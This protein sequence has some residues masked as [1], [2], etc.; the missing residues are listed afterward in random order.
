MKVAIVILFFAFQ[1]LFLKGFGQQN[2]NHEAESLRAGFLR[3]PHEAL[4]GVYWYF[5]DGNRSKESMRKDLESMKQA[6]IGNLI[7]LEVNIGMPRG[8]VDLLSKDW[9]EMFGYTVKEAR[10]LGI[11]IIL[12]IGPGWSGSG[13]PWVRPE[14]SMQHLV[15]S[16]VEAEGGTKKT[17]IL[18]LP[19]PRLPFFGMGV[20]TP[21]L[22][23]AWR[24]F[25]TDVA[26]LAFPSSAAGRIADS[27]GKTPGFAGK[28]ADID[29]KALYYRAPF[30]SAEGVKPFLPSLATYPD[31]PAQALISMHQVID[32]T[33]KLQPDGRLNWDPPAGHYTIMRFVSRN[34]GAITRPAPLPGL[35]FEADKFDTTSMNA[36][37]DA[38]VGKL[39]EASRETPPGDKRGGGLQRLHMDS[40]EMGAQ[41]WTGHFRQEFIKRRGYDPLPYYPAYAGALIGSREISERF[42]WDLRQ[43]SQEL[44]IENH[45]AQ[46]KRY[47]HRHG[48]RLSIEPYD[49]NPTADLE[50]G[51]V[52]DVP[53]PEFCSKGYGFNTVFSVI[54]A[55][56]IAHVQGKSLVPAEAFTADGEAWKQFPGSMKNQ[57]DWAFAAGI[58]QFVFHTFQNQYLADSLLPGMT[59]GPYGVNWNRSQTWWPMVGDYH[60]Y[61]SRCSYLLQQG[62]TVADILYLTPEGAPQV[63]RPPFSALTQEDAVLPDRKGYNFDGCSPGELYTATVKNHR[64]VFPSGASYRVLVLPASETMTPAL[65]AKILALVRDGAVVTGLPPKKSPGL[66]GYPACDRAVQTMAAALWGDGAGQG[67][68]HGNEHEYGKGRIIPMESSDGL[69]P[70]YEQTAA[71]LRQTGIAEDFSS[72]AP[73]RYTHRAGAGW[74]MYFV[75]NRTDSLVK[76]TAVFRSGPGVPELWDPQTGKTRRL[77]EFRRSKGISSLPLVFE[78]YQSYFVVFKGTKGAVIPGDGKNF[79]DARTL[80]TLEGPWRIAFDP[81]WGGPAGPVSQGLGDWSQSPDEGIRY[82]SGK[83]QYQK[84]FDLPA[85]TAMNKH[86][87]LW[88]DLGTVKDMARV[89]LNGKELG[90]LWTAPREVDITDAVKQMGNVLV[91]EVVNRWPNRLIGDEQWPDDG[92]K[93]DQWPDWLTK[94]LPRNSRRYTFT[95]HH[96][97]KKDS[98]LLPSGLLGPVRILAK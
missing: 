2:P 80:A 31:T 97:F 22:E 33:D 25:Y 36:H 57:G 78:P 58:N 24:D 9:L 93:D 66:S 42:L 16:S 83:V 40:W 81:R 79:P 56:S 50:L 84:K 27:P 35:G 70:D 5:M 96:P 29:E 88:L 61:V 65:L 98:P 53:M 26:V 41:N 85:L 67:F 7:F 18:P 82:Y 86:K 20:F 17:I 76:G 1:V 39:L 14:Q 28:I 75:S 73:L 34:N 15:W 71:L 6:G 55:S 44:I 62:R 64:I 47:G 32:C 59:M 49:M 11:D 4:P 95:T 45:A 54:E 91:I 48:L 87:R 43:T 52:A 63:F 30:S 21:G 72:T 94:G 60:R 37:L 92:I 19:E 74:E 46:V 77:P 23:K 12:G 90:V 69:Y 68:E 8:P 10:R 89:R 3:P 13:G 51:A 38:Y